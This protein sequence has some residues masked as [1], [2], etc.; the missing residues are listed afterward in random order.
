MRKWSFGRGRKVRDGIPLIVRAVR[1]DGRRHLSSEKET[2]SRVLYGN[3]SF[4]TK[5]DKIK[6]MCDVG[7]LN[8]GN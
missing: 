3:V 2:I 6:M 8:S 5:K 7:N 1:D 4:E